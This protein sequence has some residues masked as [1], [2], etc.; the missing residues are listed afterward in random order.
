MD[1]AALAGLTIYNFPPMPPKWDRIGMFYITFCATWTAIVFAGMAFLWANRRN[2]ILRLRGLPLAFGSIIFLHLYWCMAQITYPIGGTMPVVIAYDVQYFVMGIWFPLGIACFHASN[3][4]FLHVAKLQRLHFTGTG[5]GSIRRG[6]NGSKT[7]WLCRFRNM[8]YGRRILIFIGIGAIFQCLLTT[9]MWVACKKYHPP[10]GIPGT[11]IRGDNIV[12]QLIDL[13]RGW[14]WWPTLLWQFIWTWIVAPTLIWR[15]WSIR[16]TMGWRTQ[17]IGCCLSGLHATPM[18]LIASYVPA[19][20]TINMY[21]PPSQW[22]HLSTMM[23]EIF[24]IFVPLFQIIRL[25]ILLRNVTEANAKWETESQTTLR[26]STVTSFHGKKHPVSSS[27]AEKGQ[28][29]VCQTDSADSG[30]DIDSRLLTMTALDHALRENQGALQEFSALSDFSGEN[31]AFLARVSE[32]KSRSW[33]NAISDSESRE[34]LAQEEKL[35]AY[36][37]AL[38]IYADFISLEHADFPLNLPSQDMKQLF[39]VFD[40]PARILFGEDASV[41]TAVPF[42]DA[43][44]RSRTGSS[45]G[46]SGDIRHQARYTGDIPAG[47]SSTVFDS[48]QY[49]IKYLVLTNTWPKFVREMHSRRRSSETSRSVMTAE[50]TKSESSLLTKVSS[51]VSSLLRSVKAI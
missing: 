51:S 44:L 20:N 27:Q 19:F 18:F 17:T 13:G 36:N 22:I 50:T 25:R 3:S 15:A 48:A 10:F 30:T 21:F 14:E 39:R 32:W 35:D 42:D 49:H 29:I 41:N 38:Q 31:I 37:L 9:G 23:F 8:D 45:S 11:E 33:P 26:A 43:Y 47:F 34:S 6:C 16:D 24:T 46:S 2:P 40:K 1:P 7:S 28:P 5:A 12:E 4:R